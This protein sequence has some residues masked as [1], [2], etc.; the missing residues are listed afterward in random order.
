MATGSAICYH[1]PK[2]P[3]QLAAEKTSQ[4]L[5]KG[6]VLLMESIYCRSTGKGG[7]EGGNGGGPWSKNET[8]AMQLSPS[9]Y[10]DPSTP[11]GCHTGLRNGGKTVP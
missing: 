5:G 1:K 4:V 6:N 11:P 2:G 10:A 3:S 7:G 9:C 8:R